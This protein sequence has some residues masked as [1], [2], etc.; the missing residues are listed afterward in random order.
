M[1]AKIGYVLQTMRSRYEGLGAD[2]HGVS[3]AHIYTGHDIH[4]FLSSHFAASGLLRNGLD[5]QFRA[6]P[7]LGLEFEMDVRRIR[8]EVLA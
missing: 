1:A 2:W 7:I 4:P 3:G 6:P 5:W 8:H